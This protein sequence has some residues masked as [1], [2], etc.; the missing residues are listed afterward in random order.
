ML[1]ILKFR[2]KCPNRLQQN[3]LTLSLSLSLILPLSE[4]HSKVGEIVSNIIPKKGDVCIDL[5]HLMQ[6]LGISNTHTCI[7]VY[8]YLKAESVQIA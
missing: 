4:K 5:D 8:V 2:Y 6:A 3:I 1:T 7:Y